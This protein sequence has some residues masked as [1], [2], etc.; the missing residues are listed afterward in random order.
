MWFLSSQPKLRTLI[1]LEIDSVLTILLHA[2]VVRMECGLSITSF[3]LHQMLLVWQ[4]IPYPGTI[5]VLRLQKLMFWMITLQT[6][7]TH[8]GTKLE[9]HQVILSHLHPGLDSLHNGTTLKSMAALAKTINNVD[10]QFLLQTLL[11]VT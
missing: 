7:S 1:Q 2:Q 9:I 5:K 6:S 8:I 10:H 3:N 4:K 11:Q